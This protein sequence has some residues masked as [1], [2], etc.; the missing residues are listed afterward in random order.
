VIRLAFKLFF[1]AI[2]LVVLYVAFTYGQVWW[3]SRQDDRTPSSA[4]IVLG[5]AQ[6]N[7]KPSPVLKARLDHAAELYR[8]GVAPTIIVTGGKADGD[9]V[10]EGYAG[11]KYL[12]DEEG[13][14]EKAIKIEIG[15]TNTYEELSASAHIL[16]EGKLGRGVTLVS[17]PY[18][19]FRANAIAE[20]VGLTPHFSPTDGET[21][22]DSLVRETGGAAIGRIISFRRLSNLG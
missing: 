14:P 13:I 1:G 6:W 12:K 11:Y 21:N 10:G 8:A 2:A 16:D 5:A 18:H 20:E 9:T 19:G 15:G 4:I 17:S 3:A 7:G 22:T